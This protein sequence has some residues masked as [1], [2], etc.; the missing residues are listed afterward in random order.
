MVLSI[1]RLGLTPKAT[2]EQRKLTVDLAEVII[3]WEFQRV[4]EHQ[5]QEVGREGGGNWREGGEGGG[6]GGRRNWR[7][8]G[9]EG[10]EGGEED[11]GGGGREGRR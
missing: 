4:R 3:K 2:I 8:G 10:E 11:R 6:T 1:Q 9:M 5:D 7:E